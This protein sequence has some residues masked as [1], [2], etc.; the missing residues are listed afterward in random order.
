MKFLKKLGRFRLL[1]MILIVI[2]A[3]GI[4][5][6]CVR[7]TH[8]YSGCVAA[9]YERE[10]EESYTYVSAVPLAN[11][12]TGVLA[13]QMLFLLFRKRFAD[14]LAIVQSGVALVWLLILDVWMLIISPVGGGG[15]SGEYTWLGY[16]MVGAAVVNCFLTL[17]L[18]VQHFLHQRSCSVRFFSDTIRVEEC[19]MSL[20]VVRGDI[21]KVP[22]DAIVNAAKPSLLGG[23]GV[24]GAIHKAAGPGL[25]LE[26]MKLGGCKVGQAKITGGYR[27]P[28][29]YVIHTVGPK[30]KGGNHGEPELLASCYRE[31]LVLAKTHGCKSV[32]FPLISAGVYGYPEDQV[33]QVATQTINEFLGQEDMLVYLV[34]YA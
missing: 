32:A 6:S 16:A 23:G 30:W 14:F 12:L 8:T 31:S 11:G 17:V 29:Q 15:Y 4:N 34:I 3:V 2:L 9:M 27:L 24:D 28:C 25:L 19:S 22:C 1:L 18:F 21:T 10:P 20:Q 26:C 5:G 7:L 33:I 13:L